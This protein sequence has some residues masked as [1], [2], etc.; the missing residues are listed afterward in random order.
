MSSLDEVRSK[1]TN[2]FQALQDFLRDAGIPDSSIQM[3]RENL[4]TTCG[5]D[6]LSHR[7]RAVIVQNIQANTGNLLKVTHKT[8]H[9]LELALAYSKCYPYMN[10]KQLVNILLET[11]EKISSLRSTDQMQVKRK[12]CLLK[13]DTRTDKNL[14]L[15]VDN[16]LKEVRGMFI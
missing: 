14:L 7:N 16:L 8:I 4:N 11:W 10:P 13:S 12:Y 5:M 1:C 2:S 6:N 15:S 9:A 3:L